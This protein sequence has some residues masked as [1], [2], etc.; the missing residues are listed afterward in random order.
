MADQVD[1]IEP[2]EKFT[3][4]LQ[5][6]KGVR[7]IWNVGLEGWEPTED[8]KYDVIWTQWCVG[9]L[10]DAQLVTY[11]QHCKTALNPEGGFVVIKENITRDDKDLFD[12][13]DSSV[14]R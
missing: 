2:I 5:G 8:V 9:H 10:S 7:N 1:I 11:L 14:T 3:A 12:E 6:K 4:V 13:G